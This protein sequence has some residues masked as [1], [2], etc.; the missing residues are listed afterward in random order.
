M[1]YENS[2]FSRRRVLQA[3]VAAGVAAAMGPSV[4]NAASA[5]AP[6]LRKIP[7]SGELLPVI[8][9]GTNAFGVSAPADLD[10]IRGVLRCV[11]VNTDGVPAE[12]NVLAG[13]ATIEHAS[14]TPAMTSSRHGPPWST[15]RTSP[16]TAR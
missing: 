12:G 2:G 14:P 16:T 15:S 8:G 3:S 5:G 7:S 11:A 13:R 4:L 10:Q 6:I 1:T 9:T